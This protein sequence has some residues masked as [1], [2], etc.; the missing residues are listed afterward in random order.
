MHRPQPA[1]GMAR[2][3]RS[4]AV[5]GVAAALVVVTGLG[6]AAAVISDTAPVAAQTGLGGNQ[7]ITP[8]TFTELAA[9]VTPAVVAIRSE[10]GPGNGGEEAWRLPR[11]HPFNEFFERFFGDPENFQQFQR[12]FGERGEPGEPGQQFRFRGQ[13]RQAQASGFVISPEGH[14]VTNEHVIRDAGTI[15]VVTNDEQEYQAEVIG[16][17]PRTDLAVIKIEADADLPYVGFTSTEAQVGDWVLA[18]GNPFGLGGSV[19]S[20]IV[21][22][23]GR[24]IGSGPYDDFLQIDAAVNRGNSGGPTFNLDGEVVGVN[25]AI[26]SPNGG[27]VGIGFAIPASIASEVVGQLIEHGEI[28]RGWL[29]VSIQ[30][31]TPEIAQTIGLD[32]PTG[33]IVAEVFEDSP[34]AAAGIVPGDVI[35][36]VGDREIQS[37][38]DLARVVAD[39]APGSASDLT[40]HRDRREQTVAVEIGTMPENPRLAGLPE[41]DQAEPQAEPEPEQERLAD[42]G[43][44]VAPAS[45]VDDDPDARGVVVTEIRPGSE[46]DD[47]GI[48]EGDRILRVSGVEVNTPAELNDAL[49]SARDDGLSSVLVLLRSRDGQRFVTLELARA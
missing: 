1:P 9:T 24:H 13:P 5:R 21:S 10:G 29:G 40:V 14:V 12:R 17:D 3:F 2:P 23:R 25:T 47:K 6:G 11:D 28:T 30:T 33:A 19:T 41:E 43:L 22:A 26:Y 32:R 48:S 38:R 37:S 44:S 7:V 49:A 18:V 34:A 4:K 36:G 20:G 45:Q 42:L 39:I 15:T 27:S 35:L 31:V 46:A 8:S 16:T